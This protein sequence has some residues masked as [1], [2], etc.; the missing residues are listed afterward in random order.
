[1]ALGQGES[2]GV[3]APGRLA[4]LVVLQRDPAADIANLRSVLFT[5]K[6]GR[7]FDRADYRPI[8]A[9]EVPDE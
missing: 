1:M 7:R 4:N 2:M 8:T 3:V 9:E 5:V 6:R